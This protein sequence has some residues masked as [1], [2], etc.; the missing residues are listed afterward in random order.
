MIKRLSC[1]LILFAVLLLQTAVWPATVRGAETEAQSLRLLEGFPAA[2]FVTTGDFNDDGRLDLALAEY[3]PPDQRPKEKP[4]SRLH[5]F[6]QKAG[7]FSMPAD[8]T[9]ELPCAP[10]GLAAGDFDRHGRHDLAVGLRAQRSLAVYASGEGFATVHLSEYNNDSGAGGLSAGRLN[11]D[12]QA[13]FLTGAAWRKWMGGD[14]FN[15]AYV[16]G[17]Q[18]NDNWLPTLAD[19][20]WDGLDDLIFTTWAYGDPKGSNNLIRIYY[21]PLV[22]MG[23]IGSDSAVEVVTLI[24]PFTDSPAPVLGPVMVGD[25]NGDGQPDLVVAGPNQT[26]VYFQNSPIGFSD[27]A[28]PSLVLEGVIPLL[29]EDLDGAGLRDLVLREKDGKTI[30]IWHQKKGTPLTAKWRT[31]IYS[32][33]L[34][35]AI[36]AIAAGD[37]DGQGRKSLFVGLAQ[38]GLATVSPPGR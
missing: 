18:R 37:L 14:R 33:T 17:P 5:L 7:G 13:D 25:L 2:Q 38:G 9:I 1:T 34:P 29:L 21:G 35:R 16:C 11:R 32:V 20:N 6:Y 23:L 30:A 22:K 15:T 4:R 10:S 28:G 19:L 26:L 3:G 31:Q 12:G 8:K 24:S 36:V 27:R